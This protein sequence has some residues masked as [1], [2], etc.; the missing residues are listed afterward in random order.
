MRRSFRIGTRGSPLALRQ[1]GWV[2]DRLREMRPDIAVEVVT[3]RTAGDNNRDVSLAT[4]ESRGFFTREI[5]AALLDST[6]DMAVHSL[7]D[8]PT[9]LPEGLMIAATPEREDPRDALIARDASSLEELREGAAVAT[10]SPRR[11]AQLLHLRRDLRL[12]DVRGNIGTRLNKFDQSECDAIVLANAGLRRLG[13]EK[14]ITCA[15]EPDQFLPAASQGALAVE[16]RA[17]DEEAAQL[18]RGIDHSPTRAA[19]TAERAFLRHLAAGCRAPV[20]ALAVV[21]GDSMRLDGLVASLDGSL[22][23]RDKAEGPTRDPE[24]LGKALAERLLAAGARSVLESV[25]HD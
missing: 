1:A 15:L 25:R 4:A 11:R 18:A 3:I 8:L 9:V 14:R 10:S 2:R 21:D 20:A 12:V 22:Y 19:T 7:K 23:V 16:I 17:H 13:L 5:E 24:E 6:V